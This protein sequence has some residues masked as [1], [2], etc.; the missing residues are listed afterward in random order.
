MEKAQVPQSGQKAKKVK[1][2]ELKLPK[3]GRNKRLPPKSQAK[4]V[5]EMQ[6]LR[7]R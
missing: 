6:K 5:D 2:R 1:E 7:Q 3:K 4:T